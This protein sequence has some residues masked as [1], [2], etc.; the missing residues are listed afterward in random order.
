MTTTP[1]S[2]NS[3]SC[4]GCTSYADAK[5][6]KTS[7]TSSPNMTTKRCNKCRLV[8]S[9]SEFGNDKKSRDGFTYNCK[10]CI[11]CIDKEAR[12]RGLQ[13]LQTL[14]M[15]RTC[16]AHCQRPYSNEDWHF[17]E[18]DH[19]DS[20]CKKSDKETNIGWVAR[21]TQEFFQRV[22]PNLQ[23]LCIKCHKLKTIEEYR[24]GG[25]VH[26]KMHGQ[27]QPAQVIRHDLTLFDPSL[28]LEPGEEYS[29]HEREGE[30]ITVRDIDGN[31]IR[32]EPYSN[33]T[34][35]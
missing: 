28:T 22:E 10:H 7:S 14:A 35:H 29:L 18:F 21:H 1:S 32:Y 9:T 31:L 30:W 8:K 3:S 5:S 26:Q 4:L 13:I 27:S 11:R 6:R 20:R 19:I 23:L 15:A 25:A 12:Q 16:C 33:Y 24:F 2:A 17:F 34:K